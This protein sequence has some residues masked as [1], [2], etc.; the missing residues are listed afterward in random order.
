[1]HNTIPRYLTVWGKVCCSSNNWKESPK[2]W[3]SIDSCLYN[4][5]LLVKNNLCYRS[6]IDYEKYIIS[7]ATKKHQTAHVLFRNWTLISIVCHKIMLVIIYMYIIWLT[8]TNGYWILRFGGEGGYV[9]THDCI[10]FFNSV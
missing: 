1:M 4:Q 6:N 7:M 2:L 5:A 8:A 10:H 3:Q 9:F